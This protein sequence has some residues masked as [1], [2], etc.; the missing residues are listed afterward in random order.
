M[1]SPIVM[2]FLFFIAS[3]RSLSN[4]ANSRAETSNCFLSS[5]I[6]FSIC[7][8]IGLPGTSRIRSPDILL[9]MVSIICA[10]AVMS[11]SDIFSVRR[12][13]KSVETS[14]FFMSKSIFWT[15]MIRFFSSSY[16]R[17]QS[18]LEFRRSFICCSAVC[19]GGG[20][21]SCASTTTCTPV[22]SSTTAVSA[23]WPP[24]NSCPHRPCIANNTTSPAMI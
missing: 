23:V 4:L 13:M 6:S 1:I 11:N 9:N 5:F 17:T 14:G 22:P 21:A 3:D 19:A 16:P 2:E 7:L 15:T 20:T 10:F 24:P 8:A 18:S 12:L